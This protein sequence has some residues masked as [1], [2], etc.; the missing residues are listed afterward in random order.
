MEI[1]KGT[2]LKDR[3]RLDHLLG[4]G[5]M[6]SVWRGHDRVLDRPVAVK[7]LSDAIASDPE[8]VARFRRE[9][10]V[11]AGLSHPNLV[12]IYDYAEA[13]ERPYLVMEFV[14]GEDLG[15][16]I[17][18]GVAV[19]RDRLA[20][21]LLAA[22]SHIHRAGIVHRDVKPQN[23][24]IQADGNAKLIDFGIALPPDATALTSTGLILATRSYAAPEVMSGRPA[25]ERSDLYSCGLL[26]EACEGA[27]TTTLDAVVEQLTAE[28]PADR[29]PSALAALRDLEEGTNR[30]EDRARPLEPTE[31]FRPEPLGATE[32]FEPAGVRSGTARNRRRWAVALGLLAVVV[33]AAVVV[34]SSVG[35][36]SEAG[37]PKVADKHGGS[38]NGGRS[39][40]GAANSQQ[41]A[42]PSGESPGSNEPAEAGAGATAVDAAPSGSDPAT[43]SAL[44]EEGYE[45]IQA[46]RYEEAVPVLEESVRAFPP[47]TG[48]V[49]FAY[50]LFNL[51]E[52]LRR[53]GRP[54]EAI[55][56]LEQ[57]LQIPNQTGVVQSELEAARGEVTGGGGVS[58]GEGASAAAGG[59]AAAGN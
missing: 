45:L 2:V 26:L 15:A 35:G 5:G 38:A 40:R 54:E 28:D 20:G 56:I 4:R 29:P 50:A 9:A 22:L 8:F 6:A 31:A 14:P 17:S 1:R 39:E 11:A 12:R 41:A 58:G 59:L 44:N 57:R 25:T 34:L 10:T 51:G 21:Q 42:P 49:N 47:G 37:S 19:E 48:D 24:L 13:D 55:P 43:G 32:A 3:Y 33:A 46:G 30:F 27:S 36:G 53:S 7:L 23:V 52:A 16:L 18:G